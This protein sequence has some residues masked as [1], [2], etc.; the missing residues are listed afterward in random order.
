MDHYIADLNGDD[1]AKVEKRT[2]TN[3]N[4]SGI[5]LVVF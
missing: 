3:D 5:L 1:V 2:N 4:I